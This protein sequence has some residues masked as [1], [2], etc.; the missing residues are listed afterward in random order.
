ME[1]SFIP[2]L[3]PGEHMLSGVARTLLLLG[4][5]ALADAQQRLFGKTVALSTERLIHSAMTLYL[6]HVKGVTQRKNLLLHHSLIGFYSHGLPHKAVRAALE[7]NM[8][9]STTPF[10]PQVTKLRF[11]SSWRTCPLCAIEDERQYGTAFWRVSHQLHTSITCDRHPKV[12]LVSGCSKCSADITDLKVL[13]VPNVES[14]LLCNSAIK[15]EL[16]EHNE[17]TKWVQDRGLELWHDADDLI[18]PAHVHIMKH[19]VANLA[20]Y[21]GII[22]FS[23]LE[24]AQCD[25][26]DWIKE[27]D[28][29]VYYAKDVSVENDFVANIYSPIDHA[30]AVPTVTHLLALRFFG[31]N[32]LDQLKPKKNAN[33]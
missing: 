15:P 19:G 11:A 1:L 24:I 23:L 14:C 5:K 20:S 2:P 7:N 9:D 17:V 10:I 31:L 12:R 28:L 18:R 32:R 27:Y 16:F 3:F 26:V 21:Q 8:R 22:G 25:F 29:D 4:D 33:F 30:K 13:P 6:Q